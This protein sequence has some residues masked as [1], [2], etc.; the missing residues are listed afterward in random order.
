MLYLTAQQ[1]AIW[2]HP[3]T[4]ISLNT[5]EFPP[6]GSHD[7]EFTLA[8]PWIPPIKRYRTPSA[9]VGTNL[10][11]GIS[12]AFPL[13][14]HPISIIWF[15]DSS[16]FSDRSDPFRFP[17]ACNSPSV[18]PKK[19]I[20]S[21]PENLQRKPCYPPTSWLTAVGWIGSA[22]CK[23]APSSPIPLGDLA[24]RDWNFGVQII[25]LGPNKVTHPNSTRD[26]RI[27][28]GCSSLN[29]DGFAL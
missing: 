9:R 11:T 3:F 24:D 13:L 16:C 19:I 2:M 18:T 29:S 26:Y 28:W 8:Y 1:E 27:P 15:G 23:G 7:L 20:L 14:H 4:I 22:N 17:Q 12:L 6:S 21:R 5:M 10:C 25:R